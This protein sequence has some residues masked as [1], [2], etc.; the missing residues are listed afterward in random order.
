METTEALRRG[1]MSVHT[2]ATLSAIQFLNPDI[3]LILLTKKKKLVE[4]RDPLR[5]MGELQLST[6]R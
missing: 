1:L 3:Q 6:K 4:N 5:E 2:N